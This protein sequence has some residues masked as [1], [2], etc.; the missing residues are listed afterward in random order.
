MINIDNV[1]RGFL[2]CLLWSEC[3]DDQEPFDKNYEVSDISEEFVEEAR[4]ECQDFVEAAK[5]YIVESGM[6]DDSVGH[7]FCLT[8]NRHGAGFWDRGLGQI[9]EN[10]TKKCRDFSEF[11]IYLGDDGKI[12]RF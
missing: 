6:E 11:N 4:K 1:L 7:D 10:L 2:T 12:Y 8:R 9:G 3:D 5:E